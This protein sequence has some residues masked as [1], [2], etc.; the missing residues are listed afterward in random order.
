MQGFHAGRGKSGSGGADG[1]HGVLEYT[2]TASVMSGTDDL[3]F[4]RVY[5]YL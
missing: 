2:E 3:T 4:N 1:K 5:P